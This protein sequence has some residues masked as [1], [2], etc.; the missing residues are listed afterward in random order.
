[1][2]TL[3]SFVAL[4]GIYMALLDVVHI[5]LYDI[6]TIIDSIVNRGSYRMPAILNLC[7][8][9]FVVPPLTLRICMIV[10]GVSECTAIYSNPHIL[11]LI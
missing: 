9:P 5:D 1:M 8:V 6:M 3:S 11:D 10:G 4:M 7:G 2:A